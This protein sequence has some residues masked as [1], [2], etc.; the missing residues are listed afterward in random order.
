VKKEW[1]EKKKRKK[2]GTTRFLFFFPRCIFNLSPLYIEKGFHS[3]P[4]RERRPLSF[5][6]NGLNELM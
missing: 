6:V 4:Y 2:E 1:K 5:Q 3:T